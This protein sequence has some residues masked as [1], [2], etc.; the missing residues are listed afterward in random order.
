MS[1]C[2]LKLLLNCT[3]D[4]QAFWILEGFKYQVN[5]C[6]KCVKNTKKVI[7]VFFLFK[8]VVCDWKKKEWNSNT[9]KKKRDRIKHG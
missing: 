4:K 7:L 3:L 1:S 5:K 6:I 2:F 8:V 9:F